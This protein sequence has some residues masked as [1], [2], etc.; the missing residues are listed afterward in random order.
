MLPSTSPREA[1]LAFP[2]SPP[3]NL[4]S[5]TVESTLSSPCSGSDFPLSREGAALAHF[6]SL[7][8]YDLV[9]W[10]DV[11]VPYS[12][13]KG[14]SIVLAKCSL[15]GTETTLYFSPSP[16]CSSFSAEACTIVWAHCWSWQ[17]QQVCHFSSFLFLFDSRHSVLSSIFPF[18]LISLARTVF[19]FPVPSGYNWSPDTRFSWG[20]T[21]LMSWPDG[22]R[23]SC[24]LRFNVVS[25]LFTLVSTLVF[26]WTGGVLSHLNSLTHRNLCSLV[27]LAVFSLVFAATALSTVKLLSRQDWQNWE[28]FMQRLLA[29]VTGHLSSHSALSSYGLFTP[30]TLRWLYLRPLIQALKSCPAPGVNGLPPCPHPF[31]RGLVTTTTTK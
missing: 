3:W 19:S 9:L 24:P 12:F 23:Y 2:P 8:P 28:S 4:P 20:I 26:S 27:T 21:R 16:V 14:G 1:L 22:E 15:C 7:L 13:G 11:S 29:S 18:T 17:H 31:G 6:D 5:F 30:L 25:L 10:T